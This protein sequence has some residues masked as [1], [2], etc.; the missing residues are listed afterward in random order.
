V[1]ADSQERILAANWVWQ[2]KKHFFVIFSKI[3]FDFYPM[4]PMVS[5]MGGS[6]CPV[7]TNRPSALAVCLRGTLGLSIMWQSRQWNPCHQE[8]L[9][10]AEIQ[11]L[12]WLSGNEHKKGQR[13]QPGLWQEHPRSP[14][15]R[16]HFGKV[17]P[18]LR[19][20][21]QLPCGKRK[22]GSGSWNPRPWWRLLG[23][24]IINF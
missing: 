14:L 21:L 20:C 18:W 8:V 5:L 24:G 3:L 4:L 7:F 16:S 11:E 19:C 17:R 2:T 1:Y 23:F 22:A 10:V 6:P 13:Y 12:K 15:G 9:C